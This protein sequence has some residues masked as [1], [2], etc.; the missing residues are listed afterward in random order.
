MFGWQWYCFS[1]FPISYAH[2]RKPSGSRGTGHRLALC[3]G[4]IQEPDAVLS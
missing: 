1:S 4:Q 3:G 2:D